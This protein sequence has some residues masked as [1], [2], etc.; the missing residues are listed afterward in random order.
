MPPRDRYPELTVGAK[1]AI[2]KYFRCPDCNQS[3][4]NIYRLSD[5]TR[6]FECRCGSRFKEKDW[7]EVVFRLNQGSRAEPPG[8]PPT[9]WEHIL[10]ED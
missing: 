2:L 6:D 3:F 8:P 1:Y 7:D 5:G 9:A 10:K 4:E